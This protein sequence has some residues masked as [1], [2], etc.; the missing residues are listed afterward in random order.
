[1]RY[2]PEPRER[3]AATGIR[4]DRAGLTG[5]RLRH[6]VAVRTHRPRPGFVKGRWPP[7]DD[8]LLRATVAPCGCP[9]ASLTVVDELYREVVVGGLHQPLDGL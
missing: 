6:P 1:M 4:G 2:S 3:S 5:S 9:V 8:G 7:G